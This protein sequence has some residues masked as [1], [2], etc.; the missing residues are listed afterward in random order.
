MATESNKGSWVDTGTNRGS[1]KSLIICTKIKDN[2]S[3]G[4]N[5]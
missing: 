2:K 4:Q 5:D 3:I 1:S